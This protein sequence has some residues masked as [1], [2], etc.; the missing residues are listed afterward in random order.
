MLW[1]LLQL[2]F[3]SANHMCLTSDHVNATESEDFT[4]VDEGYNRRIEF[5]LPPGEECQFNLNSKS[6][7]FWLLNQTQY[8]TDPELDQSGRVGRFIEYSWDVYRVV[9]GECVEDGQFSGDFFEDNPINLAQTDTEAEGAVCRYY[10]YI[11]AVNCGDCPPEDRRFV[12]YEYKQDVEQW[13]QI[14]S[15]VG[16]LWLQWYTVVYIPLIVICNTF[17]FFDFFQ[18]AMREH[19]DNYMPPGIKSYQLFIDSE[20]LNRQIPWYGLK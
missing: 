5:L 10:I 20:L 6:D 12:F 17:G 14:R 13:D 4:F 16:M 7:P 2:A 11:K 19:W 1:L 18:W 9:D 15:L 8:Q 3:A